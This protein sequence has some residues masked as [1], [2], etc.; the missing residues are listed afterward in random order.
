MNS[1]A[2]AISKGLND[3]TSQRNKL[4]S[5]TYAAIDTEYRTNENNNDAKP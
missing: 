2:T 4:L 1:S 5:G 3:P